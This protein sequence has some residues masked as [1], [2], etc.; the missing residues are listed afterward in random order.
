M[1]M[2]M[3]VLLGAAFLSLGLRAEISAFAQQIGLD[4]HAVQQLDGGLLRLAQQA[5]EQMAALDALGA[6]LARLVASEEHD[7]TGF[8]SKFFE[9]G[10][11]PGKVPSPVAPMRARVG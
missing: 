11:P 4:A 3:L 2:S 7:A 8:F 10:S 5:Q 1:G 6:E 9:H